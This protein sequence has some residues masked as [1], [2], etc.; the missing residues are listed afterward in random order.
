LLGDPVVDGETPLVLNVARL[1]P[2]KG[3]HYLVQAA[4]LVLDV[5]PDV[6]FAVVGQGDLKDE[7]NAQVA[8]LGINDKFALV[9]IRSDVPDL[10]AASDVFV[11]SSLWE[12]LPI[13]LLEAMSAGCP[14]V[15]TEVGGVGGV[16]Q[17]DRTGLLVAPEDPQA[18]AQAIL[19]CLNDTPAAQRRAAAAREWAHRHYSMETWVH[20]LE[21]LYLHEL[22][23]RR[24]QS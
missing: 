17:H 1:V 21:Q 20:K 9:G 4:K 23:K 2:Q 11:L 5:R 10:M 12:G 13:S 3:I 19:S 15:A 16:V 6:R 18:L 22:G 24:T 8:E 7:L 14:V